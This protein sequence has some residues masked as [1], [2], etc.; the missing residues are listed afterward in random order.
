MTGLLDM[1][2]DALPDTRASRVPPHDEDAEQQ[3]LAAMLLDRRA[4]AKTQAVVSAEAFYRERH[5]RIFRAIAALNARNVPA[6]VTLVAE[7]LQRAGELAAVGGK[8]YLLEISDAAPTSANVAYHAEIVQER[9]GRRQIIEAA[10]AAIAE[11]YEGRI[12][13][14]AIAQQ[15]NA[16]TMSVALDAEDERGFVRFNPI[17]VGEEME[18][19]ERGEAVI[20]PT[21]FKE[22]DRALN[23]GGRAGQLMGVGGC[24]GMGKSAFVDLIALHNA[25]ASR[26]AAIFSIEMTRLEVS[27]RLMAAAS[28][29]PG[30]ALQRGH[31]TADQAHRFGTAARDMLDL[32]LWICDVPGITLDDLR[33][34][35]IGLKAEHPELRVIVVD[36]LQLVSHYLKGRR[37]D[38]ELN[39]I[40]RTLKEI[41]KRT[42]TLV[43]AA[44][45]LNSKEIEARDQK[46]PTRRDFQ[47]F[48]GL[49]NDAHLIAL[50]YRE[51]YYDE[52]APDLVEIEFVKNRSGPRF[53]VKL[54]WTGEITRI[55]GGPFPPLGW[56]AITGRD[57]Q[58]STF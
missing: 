1:P 12:E 28:A 31:L 50:L 39:T 17:E 36:Y 16:E 52:N 14:R 45:Q 27:Q 19:N 33:T 37:G 58:L 9:Y 24:P 26:G 11:A 22:I 25:I 53:A 29:V 43:V 49:L 32:P 40:S 13:A 51:K 7:E 4:I 57:E 2:N 8:E 23:G 5:R 41:A 30:A 34:R 48:S 18:R 10:T 6:D 20:I 38:E 46:R 42:E 21:G 47:G 3:V 55:E 56:A 44:A 15:L 54:P 35:A